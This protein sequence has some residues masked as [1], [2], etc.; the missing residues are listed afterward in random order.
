MT[1][2]ALYDELLTQVTGE[3][4]ELESKVLDALM[5]A[6][7]GISRSHLIHKVYDAWV[8]P[9]ELANNTYDRKIRLAVKSMRKKRLPIFSSSGEA[10][11]RLSEEP[12][13][14]EEMA[15]EFDSRAEECKA[16]AEHVRKF[17]KPLALAIREYRKTNKI[18]SQER[19][20]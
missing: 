6:P 20:L 17:Q 10:G 15:R 12:N 14:M 9:E 5:A 4:D 11:Y 2:T 16:S 3:L 8:A 1:T 7:A 19:L 13:E 18:V